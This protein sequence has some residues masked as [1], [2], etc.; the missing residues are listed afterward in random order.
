MRH[1]VLQVCGKYFQV[2]G[3]G[4]LFNR[5]AFGLANFAVDALPKLL[6]FVLL[7]WRQDLFGAALGAHCRRVEIRR[8]EGVHFLEALHRRQRVCP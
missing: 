3:S 2:L 1:L 6:L 4:W 7:Y 5:V 8:H